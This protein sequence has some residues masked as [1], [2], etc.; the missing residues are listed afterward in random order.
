MNKVV[1]TLLFAILLH[2]IIIA[3][4]KFYFTC[5]ERADSLYFAG[6]YLQSAQM[7]NTAFAAFRG[8]GHVNDRYNAARSWAIGNEPDSAFS[9]LE[10]IVYKDRYTAHYR[11]SAD[12]AFNGLH[13]NI[14]WKNL[15]DTAKAIVAATETKYAHLKKLYE[16]DLAARLDSIHESDQYYR[17]QFEKMEKRYGRESEQIKQLGSKTS[18][19]DSIN[20]I[21]V[22]QILDTRGW[23]GPEVVHG[24]N[25]AL[26]LV[27]QHAELSM[28]L[29]YLPM[30]REAAKNEKLSYA[31]LA[32]LEDRVLL[33]QNQ[34]QI[35]GTQ[36]GRDS[37][38]GKFYVSP[39]IDPDMVDKRRA[40]VGLG[41]ISDYVSHWDL[42][43]DP[44]AYKK[45]MAERGK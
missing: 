38:T 22:R 20:Q 8:K 39:L 19:N 34:K 37:I 25:A 23:L 21:K 4:S 17:R 29:Q 33:R 6:E 27:V 12:T 36:M 45:E 26:F 14:R 42:L 35:Y 31:S 9:H 1:S 5:C 32:M 44:E 7:Y 11:L 3:Q 41:P 10:K 13:R 43:W 28:Q 18:F 40:E 15:I 2:V 30:M 16:P 24:G